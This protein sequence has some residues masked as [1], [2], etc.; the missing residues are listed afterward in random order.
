MKTITT[1]T[2]AESATFQ[3]AIPHIS[4]K[5]IATNSC[6]NNFAPRTVTT[7]QQSESITVRV[8]TRP[9]KLNEST[10]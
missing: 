9:F 10:V 3:A 5:S 8:T 6:G 7:K 1:T 2:V 4:S